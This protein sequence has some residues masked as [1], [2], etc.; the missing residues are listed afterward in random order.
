MIDAQYAVYL[1][2]PGSIR[3]LG[4]G[5]VWD[6]LARYLKGWTR[7]NPSGEG[8]LFCQRPGQKDLLKMDGKYTTP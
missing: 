3:M 7:L 5:R 8:G 1:R 2:S 6:G 4:K